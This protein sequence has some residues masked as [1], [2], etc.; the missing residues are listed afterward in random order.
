M[1]AE[2]SLHHV[3]LHC[4]PFSLAHPQALACA[5]LTKVHRA[6]C[7]L[8]GHD[9]LLHFG[10]RRVSLTCADCGWESPGWRLDPPRL[11][12][13]SLDVRTGAGA[14]PRV[15]NHG[16]RTTCRVNAGERSSAPPTAA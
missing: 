10:P 16:S 9:L 4:P 12:P 2:H 1:L 8:R 5:I 13:V 15:G 3:G 7:A 14:Y 11:V 6:W